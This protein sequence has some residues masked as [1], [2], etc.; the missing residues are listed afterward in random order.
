MTKINFEFRNKVIEEIPE[1]KKCLQCGTCTS[2]CYAEKYIGS[3]N[4][5]K[6][7]LLA[8]Y[9]QKD[10]LSK[11][12]WKCSTCNSCNER[13]PRGVNPY[14]V[15]TRLKNIAVRENISPESFPE[16]ADIIIETGFAYPIDDDVNNARKTLGLS[17]IK[18]KESLKF[19]KNG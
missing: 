11:E 6:K 3:Y 17:E 18:Q 10:I 7:I 14:E 8:L 5:R 13:C 2:S 9:G 12:L 1:I 4:P 19:I 16:K 15:L